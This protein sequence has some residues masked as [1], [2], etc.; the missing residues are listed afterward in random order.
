[1]SSFKLKVTNFS[2]FCSRQSLSSKS[3][4]FVI[5][6]REEYDM[7]IL[8]MSGQF[9]TISEIDN[10]VTFIACGVLMSEFYQINFTASK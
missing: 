5:L 7:L 8:L 9:W 4:L 3:V 10:I 6:L 2:L 1:M